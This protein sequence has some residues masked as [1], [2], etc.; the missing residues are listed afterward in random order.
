MILQT[1]FSRQIETIITLAGVIDLDSSKK[2]SSVSDLKHGYRALLQS[3][4]QRDVRVGATEPYFITNAEEA[5]KLRVFF[6]NDSLLDDKAQAAVINEQQDDEALEKEDRLV[7]A[8]SELALYSEEHSTLLNTIITDIF[9][10]P[11]NIAKGGSTSQAI[12]VI[13]ANPQTTYTTADMI[14]ILVHELTHHAMFLDELRYTHY[15]YSRVLNQSTWAH[16]A[17]L[18]VARPLDKVLHSIVVAVEILLFRERYLGHPVNPRVHPPTRLMIQQ[19][20]DSILS[21]EQAIA[22]DRTVF[23]PRARELLENAR[24]ILNNKLIR[25]PVRLS[26]CEAEANDGPKVAV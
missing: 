22:R 4:G 16:S 26:T 9:V 19:L 5:K 8:L 6:S 18:N 1:S 20:K 11:S 2:Y 25:M 7:R 17:I 24:N 14:E 15:S 21:T 10:L 23:H 13:W 3:L 12:G